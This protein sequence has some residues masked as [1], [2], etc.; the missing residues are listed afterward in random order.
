[1]SV[2]E[3][4]NTTIKPLTAPQRLQ[5]ARMILEGIPPQ[6]IVDYNDE[7]TEEDLAEFSQSARSRWNETAGESS[8]A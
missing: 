6:S 2:A 7:W 8:D 5:L 4:Y 3:L 1:M